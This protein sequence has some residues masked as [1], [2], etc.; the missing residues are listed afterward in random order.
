[1]LSIL[2]PKGEKRNNNFPHVENKQYF[3]KIIVLRNFCNH[4]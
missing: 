2:H 3:G 4:P 1:V